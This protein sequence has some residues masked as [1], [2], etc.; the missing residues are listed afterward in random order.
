MTVTAVV[1]YLGN[2]ESQLVKIGTSTN[3]RHRIATLRIERPQLVL[4]ATEP[5][6][7][8][9][10]RKRHHQFRHLREWM[11]TGEREWFRKV[12][13]LMDHIGQI[14]LRH[15]IISPGSHVWLDMVA[16]LR[17]TAFRCA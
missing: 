13:L 16:P 2:P 6:T 7:Y 4:L 9:T 11:P 3:L 8:P 14:R 1:Y 5:G 10:E 17:R 15:G 12:P